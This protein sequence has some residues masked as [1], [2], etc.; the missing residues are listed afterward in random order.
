MYLQEMLVP[1]IHMQIWLA[2]KGTD[3]R[4]SKQANNQAE[5]SKL[6]A[7]TTNSV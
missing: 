2:S 4:V 3:G 6:E 7:W 1:I 5:L